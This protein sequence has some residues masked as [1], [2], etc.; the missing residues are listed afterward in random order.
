MI[1][2]CQVEF[3]AQVAERSIITTLMM[4]IAELM[5]KGKLYPA[6]SSPREAVGESSQRKKAASDQSQLLEMSDDSGAVGRM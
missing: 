5:L 4:L 2:L 1:S 3:T 6:D